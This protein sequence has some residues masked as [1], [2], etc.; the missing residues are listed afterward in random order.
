MQLPDT[1]YQ[2]GKLFLRESLVWNFMSDTVVMLRTQDGHGVIA[3]ACASAS[4]RLA[5]AI[6]G[7]VECRDTQ[8]GRLIG[9]LEQGLGTTVFHF[10]GPPLVIVPGRFASIFRQSAM[11]VEDQ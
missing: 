11:L 5:I 7:V 1:N 2:I 4:P 8:D 6:D 10:Q 3:L 9:R